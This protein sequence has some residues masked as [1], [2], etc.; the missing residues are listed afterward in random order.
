MKKRS[1]LFI[2]NEPILFNLGDLLSCPL[3]YFDFYSENKESFRGKYFDKAD[4]VILGGGAY[5]DFGRPLNI[6][7]DKSIAWGIGSSIRGKDSFPP[8]AVNLPY[9]LYG[10]RDPESAMNDGDVL[11]CVSCMHSFVLMRPEKE[12]SIF[13]NKDSD[14]IAAGKYA[15]NS[16]R[17]D[18]V[19]SNALNELAF[20]KVFGKSGY[21]I[22]NS[23]HV[24]YWSFLS[25]RKVA[26]LGYSSKLRS[27]CRL[28]E[29]NPDI[30]NYYDTK[31]D[32]AEINKLIEKIIKNKE[33]NEL[34]NFQDARHSCIEKN[35]KFAKLCVKE[36]LLSGYKIRKITL[37]DMLRRNIKA[38]FKIYDKRIRSRLIRQ[39]FIK[40]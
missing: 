26:L 24:A 38:G 22:T 18:H 2:R 36:G 17:G 8:K 34:K 28:L 1:I 12:M 37:I 7:Y 10:I 16:F 3:Y 40:R 15:G 25:G 19:Y 13:L 30:V 29:L 11:P 20:M 35:I 23:Y 21:I 33:F 32:V 31:S 9:K 6:P 4:T 14:I 5:T 27:L 39:R